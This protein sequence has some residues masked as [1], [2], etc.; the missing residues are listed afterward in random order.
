M[1][2]TLAKLTLSDPVEALLRDRLFIQL[3]KRSYIPVH[4]GYIL[5]PRMDANNKAILRLLAFLAD[6]FINMRK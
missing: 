4:L 6:Y 3:N 1:A 2:L 5:S